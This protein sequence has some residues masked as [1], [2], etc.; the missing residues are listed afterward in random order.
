MRKFKLILGSDLSW[1][2][3]LCQFA[4]LP[5]LVPAA[6]MVPTRTRQVTVGGI[7]ILFPQLSFTFP[8]EKAFEYPQVLLL[9]QGSCQMPEKQFQGYSVCWL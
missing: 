4:V 2:S 9:A 3:I 1:A 8:D 7:P 6:S 5:S